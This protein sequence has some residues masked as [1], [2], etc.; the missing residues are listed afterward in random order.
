VV[1][2]DAAEVDDARDRGL[3]LKAQQRLRRLDVT[4]AVIGVK[5]FLI[6]ALLPSD[7]A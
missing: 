6:V 7:D 1:R 2:V 3:G 5:R 4:D